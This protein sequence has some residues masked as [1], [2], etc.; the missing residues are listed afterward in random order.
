M[1]KSYGRIPTNAGCIID[2]AKGK[3]SVKWKYPDRTPRVQS[4]IVA[5]GILLILVLIIWLGFLLFSLYT[6]KTPA[7]DFCNVTYG[8]NQIKIMNFTVECQNNIKE[9]YEFNSE[10]ISLFDNNKFLKTIYQNSLSGYYFSRHL[11]YAGD[12]AGLN[13]FLYLFLTV[14]CMIFTCGLIIVVVGYMTLEFPNSKIGIK[15]SR[16][17]KLDKLQSNEQKYLIGRGYYI[18]FKEVPESKVLEIPLF[19]NSLLDY[20]AKGEFS[21]YLLRVEI[22]EHPFS[23]AVF[24]IKKIRGKKIVRIKNKKKNIYLWK[25]QFIFSDIPKN[26]ELEVRFK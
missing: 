25:A 7:P 10:R 21:K 16:K 22:T 3:P 9:T 18:K 5:L 12:Y 19:E 15:I 11:D 14:V 26:G 20:K 2:Y 8:I 23:K 24:R 6:P 4:A 13:P 17:L 1:V